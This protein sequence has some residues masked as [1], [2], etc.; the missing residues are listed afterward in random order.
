M[1]KD[2]RNVCMLFLSIFTIIT[3]CSPLAN[4]PKTN[5]NSNSINSLSNGINKGITNS[6]KKTFGIKNNKLCTLNPW[7]IYY[8]QGNL[9]VR[10]DTYKIFCYQNGVKIGEGTCPSYWANTQNIAESYSYDYVTNI[11]QYYRKMTLAADY[12]SG[13][14]VANF[15]FNLDG[16]FG[17]STTIEMQGHIKQGTTI[18]INNGYTNALNEALSSTANVNGVFTNGKFKVTGQY[19]STDNSPIAFAVNNFTRYATYDINVEADIPQRCLAFNISTSSEGINI[20]NI[21]PDGSDA[22][23]IKVKKDSIEKVYTGFGQQQIS[24]NGEGLPEGIYNVE[25][26]FND[27]PNNKLTDTLE[28]KHELDLKKVPEE[29]EFISPK[30]ADGYL[31]DIKFDVIASSEWEL[32]VNGKKPDIINADGTTTQGEPCTWTK[33]GNGN[34]NGVSWNGTCSDGSFMADGDYT[35]NLTSTSGSSSKSK[36]IKI[37]N[38]SPEIENLD[39]Q[40]TDTNIT[41]EAT[42]KDPQV[43][44]VSSG[45]DNE[46]IDMIVS[47]SSLGGTVSKSGSSIKYTIPITKNDS[48]DKVRD[49]ITNALSSGIIKVNAKDNIKNNLS[50]TIDGILGQTSAQVVN[51]DLSSNTKSFS[52]KSRFEETIYSGDTLNNS[53]GCQ[54]VRV[55]GL[56]YNKLKA[57]VELS[58]VL[59]KGTY[60]YGEEI[61]RWDFTTLG[62]QLQQHPVEWF[63]YYGT[64][65]TG[66][67]APTGKYTFFL[68]KKDISK[69]FPFWT[70]K[71]GW[72]YVDNSALSNG[73]T[74]ESLLKDAVFRKTAKLRLITLNNHPTLPKGTKVNYRDFSS[75]GEP[76]LEIQYPVNPP[77]NVKI[78]YN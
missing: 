6:Q 36:S 66:T 17:Y 32:K 25:A 29:Q 71:S 59:R 76:T 42:L 19:K 50:Q 26:Y 1:K 15:G 12:V 14:T 41:L 3:A 72:V 40:E 62:I 39:I 74:L 63:G 64:G 13:K 31:D 4:T 68:E 37:D 38:T 73:A 20:L 5:T 8:P 54:K 78:R 33:S 43:N 49:S 53:I 7:S 51:V 52:T 27:D 47:D 65:Q 21:N 77:K 69:K 9:N 34:Q 67:L 24:F 61:A 10:I 75:G 11:D 28:V 23:T 48:L 55:Y 2:F 46:S 35:V 22:W 60:K 45:L 18:S 57:K 30:T 56:V 16:F 70:I 58:V 44:G